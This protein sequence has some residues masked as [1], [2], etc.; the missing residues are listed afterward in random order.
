MTPSPLSEAQIHQ[1]ASAESFARGMS[2][3]QGG[4]VGPLVLRG[5]LLQTEVEGSEYEPYRVTVSL[6]RGG[7]RAA[8]C[9]CP[10]D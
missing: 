8:N 1:H 3:Y 9:T 10:Y 2:Y 4:A 6:D 7:V 5:D